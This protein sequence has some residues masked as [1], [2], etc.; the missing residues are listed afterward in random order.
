MIPT[1]LLSTKKTLSLGGH[2]S[3]TILI[4][5]LLLFIAV[6]VYF[7]NAVVLTTGT[8]DAYKAQAEA[9][10]QPIKFNPTLLQQAQTF[11]ANANNT[12]LPA[13]RVNPFIP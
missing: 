12:S 6:C 10:A 8:D 3:L 13:G 11:S 2:R 5:A 4:V 9:A 1:K 7:I